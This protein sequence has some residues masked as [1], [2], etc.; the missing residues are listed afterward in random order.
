MRTKSLFPSNFKKIGL[1]ILIPSLIFGCITIYMDVKPSFF[2]WNVISIFNKSIMGMGEESR[3]TIINNNVLGELL[4]IIIIIGGLF[5]AFSSEKNEDEFI[6]AIR[7]DSLVWAVII[8]Y[9]ILIF[10]I[11][12]IYDM[13]FLDVLLFN[14][15]TTL[16][17]F[18]LKF[19]WELRKLNTST[20]NEE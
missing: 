9:L 20:A 17:I 11:L 12:F 19:N 10:S 8:N 13:R 14:M 3:I 6:T 15:F 1:F 2:D 5:V 7:L 4:G 18:I 16:F